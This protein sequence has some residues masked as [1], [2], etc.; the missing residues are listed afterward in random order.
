MKKLNLKLFAMLFVAAA[1]LV[2]CAS[3]PK[4]APKATLTKTESR[5]FWRIDGTDANGNPSTVYIQGTFHLGDERIYPLSDEVLNA[6]NNAD[7]W[8]GEISTAGYEEIAAAGPAL[9][10]PNPDGKI[11]TDYLDENEV[12]FLQTVFGQN[13][14]FV[15]GLEPWQTT[16]ALGVG[17]YTATGLSAEYGL[18]NN[19]IATLAQ[20]GKSWDGL[21]EAKVQLD[22]IT[23][24]D[25]DTQIQMLK[26]TLKVFLDPENGEELTKLTVDL[27]N[28]YLTNDEKSIAA[29]F[30]QSDADE[31]EQAAFYK[32]Y[33]DMVY[34][35]R[36]KDWA[37]DITEY[38]AQ[39]GT[40]FIFAG[41]AHWVGKESVFTFLKKM[42][43]IR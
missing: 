11:V 35:N 23:F 31:E 27:Y 21:D 42:G 39:G 13:L 29:L 33:H 14:P 41:T 9:N 22:I 12:A 5:M 4:A 16:T 43:T 19:F 20:N 2:S 15:A 28:A 36:N 10:A 1:L 7:R 24:G 3:K 17:M 25:Y 6:F 32:E 30:E 18:D 26:D 37:N 40:T 8:A 38:L 34:A